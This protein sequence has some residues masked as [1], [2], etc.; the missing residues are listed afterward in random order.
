MT[1]TLPDAHELDAFDYTSLPPS[2]QPYEG[3]DPQQ[4]LRDVRAVIEHAI[5]HHPRSL[6]KRIG[7]SEI[8]T[9][10]DHCL[11]AK[12]AG[13]SQTDDGVPWLPTIGT[14]VHAWC[15]EQFIAH[16]VRRNALHTTGRRWL[17]EQKVTVGRIGGVDIAGST[18]LLDTVT[19]VVIDFKIVGPSTLRKAKSGPSE[20]Y[21]T[22][23]D[24]YAKGWN[25]AGYRIDHVAIAYLP[26][27]AASLDHA[28]W[29][30]APHDR[31]RAEA[32][33]DRANRL[34]ANLTALASISDAARDAWITQLPRADG[35]WDCARYPD[36]HGLTKPGHRPPADTLA[37]LIP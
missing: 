32:A 31:S 1:T 35:C 34:H 4:S 23:A 20:V 13:W 6:Q 27:N 3:G 16:E 14:A 33:L 19:G 37:G 9:P 15:E 10:C 12:L 30:S 21:R 36:G 18:D 24:L 11:A 7:P 28:V 22:Q 25:D 17:T 8:G 26:R 29:W 2:T 5:V